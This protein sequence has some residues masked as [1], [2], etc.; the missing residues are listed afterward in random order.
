[1]GAAQGVTLAPLYTGLPAVA[2]AKAGDGT[3]TVFISSDTWPGSGGVLGLTRAGI[4]DA[5]ARGIKPA[6][7]AL[8]LEAIDVRPEIATAVDDWA[9][10]NVDDELIGVQVRNR[11]EFNLT[12]DA[13][14]ALPPANI[15]NTVKV[16]KVV[17]NGRVYD[18]AQLVSMK[19]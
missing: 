10:T 11:S 6:G 8:R 14:S 3:G 18:V 5:R 1:M 13:V 16:K 15:A 17:A 2:S 12:K 7:G 9:A 4:A 19:Q